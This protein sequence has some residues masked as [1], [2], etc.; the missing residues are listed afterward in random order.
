[1][2]SGSGIL[3]FIT[4]GGIERGGSQLP[5]ILF[6]DDDLDIR[7]LF[8][9]VLKMEGYDLS[10][11]GSCSAAL[12]LI[13]QVPFDMVIAD[14]RMADM[15]V[16]DFLFKVFEEYPEARLIIFTGDDRFVDTDEFT[17]LTRKLP[18]FK[19]LLKPI[20]HGQFLDEV[21]SSFAQGD[22]S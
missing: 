1:M 11:A 17:E 4:I 21:K 10:E 20:R 3:G 15:N 22:G 13:K 8:V 16:K 18:Y 2:G 5:R 12:D 19:L 6:V 9:H 14:L 7:K